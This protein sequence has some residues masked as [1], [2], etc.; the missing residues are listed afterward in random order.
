MPAFFQDVFQFRPLFLSQCYFI[1]CHHSR[2]CGKY[3]IK[4]RHNQ[5]DMTL[6]AVV[7]KNGIGGNID[8]AINP[9]ANVPA[10][11]VA[12]QSDQSVFN[13]LKKSGD[14]LYLPAAG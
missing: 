2:F 4:N 1:P 3:K 8:P 5:I 12:Y 14:Y 10:T 11:W 6:V 7:N 13:N 9:F